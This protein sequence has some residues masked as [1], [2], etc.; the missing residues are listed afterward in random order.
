MKR[1]AF[2]VPVCAVLVAAPAAAQWT[3]MP[4]WNDPKGGTGITVS[5]EYGKPDSAYGKGNAW[6]GRAAL[7]VG[8]VTLTAG[9]A[10]YKPEGSSDATTAVG[11]QAAFRVIGGS[12]LPFAV[13]LQAGGGKSAQITPSKYPQRTRVTR[14]GGVGVRPSPPGVSLETP[15]FPGLPH[16]RAGGAPTRVSPP[17]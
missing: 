11:G 1:S 17:P 3:G 9:V 15:F 14:A 10:T 12:L 13:N 5:G 4:V 8:T 6:G 2:V 16:L 7:G